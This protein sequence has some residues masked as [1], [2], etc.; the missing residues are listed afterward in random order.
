MPRTCRTGQSKC[1]AARP[2]S[3]VIRRPGAAGS[4]SHRDPAPRSGLTS[5]ARFSLKAFRL[6]PSLSTLAMSDFYTQLRELAKDKVMI[7][8][9][10]LLS[11]AVVP[12]IATVYITK[13]TTSAAIASMITNK[14]GRQSPSKNPSII[15]QNIGIPPLCGRSPVV[16]DCSVT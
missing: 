1:Y 8:P 5:D 7:H 3:C 9:S 6:D 4:L 13:P 10:W 14:S 16:V 2:A 11:L 12:P 15:H